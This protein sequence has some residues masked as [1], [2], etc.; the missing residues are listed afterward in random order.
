MVSSFPQFQKNFIHAVR[1]WSCS[2]LSWIHF[3]FL[4]PAPCHIHFNITLPPTCTSSKLS[5]RFRVSYEN[6]LWVSEFL[7]LLLVPCILS[8]FYIKAVV[9]VVTVNILKSSSHYFVDRLVSSSAL[10][11]NN[12]LIMPFPS[13]PHPCTFLL[14]KWTC[15][16]VF[17]T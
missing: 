5:L 7:L 14:V 17:V 4:R 15:P 13:S 11:I 9:L 3:A 12:C 2:C 6:F 8:L 10:G 16:C 1:R